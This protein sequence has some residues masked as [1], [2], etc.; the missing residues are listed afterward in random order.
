MRFP[1]EAFNRAHFGSALVYKRLLIL[2]IISRATL[3]KSFHQETFGICTEQKP[4]KPPITSG[5]YI[6]Q[7]RRRYTDRLERGRAPKN[8]E[9]LRQQGDQD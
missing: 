2:G 1:Q 8:L 6:L 4:S 5:R 9:P 7:T 3:R